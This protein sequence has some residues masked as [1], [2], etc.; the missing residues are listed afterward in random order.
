MICPEDSFTNLIRIKHNHFKNDK[1]IPPT[2]TTLWSRRLIEQV[3]L[4]IDGQSIYS[5]L[6]IR[7]APQFTDWEKILHPLSSYLQKQ[8]VYIY[9]VHMLPKGVLQANN[10]HLGY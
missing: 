8:C 3:V 2:P 5:E 4:Y 1:F 6:H 7:C 9:K 10:Y